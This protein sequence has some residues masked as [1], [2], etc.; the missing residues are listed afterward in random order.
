[1][2]LSSLNSISMYAIGYPTYWL[3]I[4]SVPT[5]IYVHKICRHN[6]SVQSKCLGI[7]TI[8]LKMGQHRPLFRLYLVFS[9][10]H[11]NN[12]YNNYMLKNVHPL[13]DGEIRIHDLRKVS[14]FP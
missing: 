3:A 4:G 8:F 5:Y 11:N 1:M 6:Y 10:K 7:C 9:N 14:L 12:F 13:Y 2:R